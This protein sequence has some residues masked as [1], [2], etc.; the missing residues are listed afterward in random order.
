MS[1]SSG[2]RGFLRNEYLRRRPAVITNDVRWNILNAK[3]RMR[4]F[5]VQ[6]DVTND[7]S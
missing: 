2:F 7:W 3:E 4:E 5:G 6:D 1:Y